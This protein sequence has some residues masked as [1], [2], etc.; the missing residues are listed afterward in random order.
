MG[1]MNA[2]SSLR[3][4]ELG[5]GPTVS[6][7]CMILAD[8][9]AEVLRIEPPTPGPLDQ[10]P[11]APM[12]QRGKCAT[13]LDLDQEDDVEA[14]LELLGA[15][16]VLVTNWRSSK[17][18][19]R[20]L[21]FEHLSQTHPHLNLCHITG[22]GL[23]GPLSD[24]PAYEHVVAA[25][26]GRMLQFAGLRD[27]AGPAWSAVQVATHVATQSAVTGIL[28][29][30]FQ[31]SA[32]GKGRYIETSLMKGLLPYDMG[33]LIAL[34]HP[35][36]FAGF[37]PF[38]AR[39]DT[40][41]KPSLYYHPAQAGDGQWMQ[42]GN[43]LPH[44][45]DNFLIATDLI[46]VLA[47]PL[48]D[49][50][51][52]LLTEEDA[53]EAFR[54]RMLGRIQSQP[55][56]AW[57]QT[58]IDDGGIV[59][60]A[61]QSTQAAMDDPDLVD[62]GHVVPMGDDGLQIGPLAKLCDTPAHI[63]APITAVEERLSTWRQ[64][65]RSSKATDQAA[66][67]PL[68]GIRVIEIATI[69]AAPLG[70]SML[71]D[72]GAEVIK[73]E[74]IAGDPFRSLM[75]GLGAMRV[76]AGKKSL[77]VNLKTSE[78]KQIVL[79]L[80][81][82]ADIVIHNY[83]PGV[84]ERLGIDYASVQPL[85]PALVYIQSNGYGP[86]GPSAHRPSTHPIPGAAM[87]GVFYQMGET[88]PGELLGEDDLVLWTSRLMRANEL[89]PDP[90]T[91]AVIAT[92]ALLGLSARLRTG[93]G[94]QVMVDMFGA[95]A[96]ANADDFVRYPGKEA[97]SLPDAGLHGLSAGYRLYECLND[98]WVFLALVTDTDRETFIHCL[99]E[100]DIKDITAAD[101]G[102]NDDLT[103]EQLSKAFLLHSADDWMR[104]CVD[105]GVSCVR[106][107][108]LTPAQFLSSS[109]NPHKVP[110]LDASL[111]AYHRHAPLIEFDETPYPAGAAP[112][113]GQHTREVLLELGRTQAEINML[114]ERGAIG[115]R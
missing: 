108:H 33:G 34:Q 63:Q 60:T 24:L 78:G 54:Q 102:R 80:I 15:A 77:C 59:G 58:L 84:P 113:M 72:L 56:A 1:D 75:S 67:P 107:D 4:V 2:L 25:H 11:A 68:Q 93:Q 101:L 29:A 95:N 30:C 66:S 115:A 38:L 87:G 10:L 96:Y 42:F 65:P 97:R 91:S 43:L 19:A 26:T 3:V 79:D 114:I 88:L 112:L 6:L 90:N 50:A 92:S 64:S 99:L 83:R 44:L 104:L 41:P 18:A 47:D 13:P 31:Q 98:T 27:R 61:Y 82:S 109:Q 37:L 23:H 46:D 86:H 48:Y 57:M 20:G 74:P 100:M 76:N 70:A 71:A 110:A 62:N 111:G 73:I 105:K 94:Q 32:G 89:N 39:N 16:D 45:F 49:P 51:Q 103:A 106:A 21:G 28:A 81:Q 53:H 55:S 52:M 17:L 9:G 35:E 7:A 40:P 14:L 69:I 22:F 12:W 85:N 36:A 5:T 8:F